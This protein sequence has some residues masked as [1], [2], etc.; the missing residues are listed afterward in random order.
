ML[1]TSFEST[2]AGKV[3]EQ[4]FSLGLVFVSDKAEA[5]E[6]TAECVF[7]VVHR[8]FRSI[9]AFLIFTHFA[10]G[11][12]EVAVSLDLVG[13]QLTFEP[14]EGNPVLADFDWS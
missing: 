13:I 9:D 4:N 6:K 5:E 8:F 10:K 7:L 11:S 3:A 14:R 12:N 2:A 1:D